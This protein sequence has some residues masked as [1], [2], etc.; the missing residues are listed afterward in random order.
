MTDLLP[1]Q[2]EPANE[3]W[4]HEHGRL[5]HECAEMYSTELSRRPPSPKLDLP[6]EVRE[7][8]AYFAKTGVPFGGE[9]ADIL[10]AFIRR[11][12]GEGSR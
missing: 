11:I 7:A 4:C 9:Q 5:P 8:M 10:C 2:F 12:A 3:T 1:C 6:Q